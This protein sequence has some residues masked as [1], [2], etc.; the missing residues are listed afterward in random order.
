MSQRIFDL[1]LHHS[2]TPLPRRPRTNAA[3]RGRAPHDARLGDTLM[4]LIGSP[5]LMLPGLATTD[6]SYPLD[7]NG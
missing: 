2:S 5:Y 7:D 3:V 4:L 1:Y 6:N